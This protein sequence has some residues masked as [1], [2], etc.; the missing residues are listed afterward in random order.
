MGNLKDEIYLHEEATSN[1]DRTPLLLFFVPGN[2]GLIEYYRSYLVHLYDTTRTHHPELDLHVYGTS[3]LGF[4]VGT[5]SHTNDETAPGPS[6]YGPFDLADQSTQLASTLTWLAT[7]ILTKKSTLQPGDVRSS[8]LPVILLGHSVGTWLLLDVVAQQQQRLSRGLARSPLLDIR[9]A[10]SLFPTIYDLALSPRG[11]RLGPLLNVPGFILLVRM[12]AGALMLLPAT[13]LEAFVRT[14]TGMPE[15]GARVTAAFLRSA[16]GVHQALY[17]AKH[18]LAVIKSEKESGWSEEFW[19]GQSGGAIG[20]ESSTQGTRLFFYW[21]RDD[22]WVAEKTRARVI[23]ARGSDA[24]MV[25]DEHGIDHAF[26]LHSKDSRVV[27]ERSADFVMEAM[28][29]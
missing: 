4:E 15:E 12:L 20:R 3:L 17:L 9:A 16:A 2:P 14:V 8:P 5:P 7:R 29:K 11:R 19:D 18:E 13:V 22:Y 21:G 25:I 27:A 6:K 10:V 1:K 26:C 23:A 24:A 28:R